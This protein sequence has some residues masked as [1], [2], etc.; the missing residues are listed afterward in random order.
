MFKYLFQKC[1]KFI[2]ITLIIF[3][4]LLYIMIFYS[5]IYDLCQ[6]YYIYFEKSLAVGLLMLIVGYYLGFCIIFNYAMGIF[7]HPG[8]SNVKK[9]RNYQLNGLDESDE[10]DDP[11]N[12][13]NIQ[14]TRPKIC[15]KCNDFKPLRAHHCSICNECIYKMDHHC[16]WLD[17]CVGYE[18]HRYFLSFIFYLMVSMFYL[19]SLFFYIDH[20]HAGFR[21]AKQVST[22]IFPVVQ[23]LCYVL[24]FVLLAFNGWN[25]YLAM[26][27][28]TAVEFW[29][30]RSDGKDPSEY[31][32]Q[33]PT[34]SQNLYHIFGTYSYFK[35][36][37]PSTRALPHDGT[38]WECLS[39]PKRQHKI[40]EDIEKQNQARNRNIQKYE[41]EVDDEEEQKFNSFERNAI[42]KDRKIQ[43]Q[44]NSDEG[45]DDEMEDGL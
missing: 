23:L 10:D 22:K 32:F 27:G 42:I 6:I 19:S 7:V 5:Y 43:F 4:L 45:G 13:V 29:G 37:L 44:G 40:N 30:S 17:N 20:H 15:R 2:G 16:P 25:W 11:H 12:F 41:D 24:S 21:D 28:Y 33:Y 36:L 35:M 18:N 26:K 34:V 3:F 39:Q 14:D 1:M 9:H 38:K 8:K 31:A